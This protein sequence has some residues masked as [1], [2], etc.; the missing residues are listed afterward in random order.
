MDAKLKEE[1]I[2]TMEYLA[3]Q[4]SKEIIVTDRISFNKENYDRHFTTTSN[5]R[6]KL[7]SFGVRISGAIAMMEGENLW[8]EFRTYHIQ[9]IIRTENKIDLTIKMNEKIVRNI[10]IEIKPNLT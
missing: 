3:Q 10:E 6:F 8:F 5:L 1:I 2:A 9:S 7:K 4:V